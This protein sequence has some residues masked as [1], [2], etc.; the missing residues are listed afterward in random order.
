MVKTH[1]QL[2]EI[3]RLSDL[4]AYE[5]LDS[6]PE[7]EF[8]ELVELLQQITQCS[9]VSISFL[10]AHRQ[11]QKAS[12]GHDV[13]VDNREQSFCFHT[14][15]EKKPLVVANT[16]ADI[17]FSH[18]PA[19]TD[20]P[21]IRFYAG[22]P[23]VSSNGR[24]IGAVCAFDISEREFSPDQVRGM[25]IVAGQVTKLLELRI[26]NK[27]AIR[28]AQELLEKERKTLEHTIRVQEAERRALGEELHENFA[29][30]IAACLMYINFALESGKDNRSMVQ[31]AK[32]ELSNLL[33]EI[34]RLSRA[35]NPLCFPVV[36]LQDIVQELVGQYTSD[37]RIE[38]QVDWEEHLLELPND[39]ALNIFRTLD[40]YLRLVRDSGSRGHIHLR[41]KVDKELM[42]EIRDDILHDNMSETEFEIRL[43]AILGRIGIMEGSYRMERM[44]GNTNLFQV[45][46]P[47]ALSIAC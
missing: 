18:H 45:R 33:S 5:I 42:L 12:I 27:K 47:Y 13:D 19:V 36:H 22:T 10:G 1:I 21:H 28:V 34:R 11:W 32:N 35:Y 3:M 16:L 26:R 37:D 46:L 4:E 41:L 40:A 20:F 43:N 2:D 29:Q 39:V 38:I 25:E 9:Y 17:R 15:L 31:N 24:N 6:A 23:I 44:E 8:N 30:V 7:Q 14:I